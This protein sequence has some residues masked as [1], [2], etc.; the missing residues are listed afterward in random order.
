MS[1][2]ITSEKI[3]QLWKQFWESSPRDHKRAKPDSLIPSQEDKTVLF[4][5]AWMQQFVPYLMGK[6]H[7]LGKRLY[8]IQKCV[9]TWDIDEVGDERHLTFFEMMGNW[10]L[11]DYFKKEAISWSYEFLTDY[12][13]IPSNKIWATI[14]KWEKWIPKD[15]ESQKYWQQVGVPAERIKPLGADDNF[16]GPA[17]EIW[18]CGPSTEIYVDRWPAWGP[19]DR[20]LGT[21]DRYIEVWNDVFMEFYKDKQ[22]NYTPLPQKNVDTWMGLERITMIMQEV[23]TVFETDLFEPIIKVIAKHWMVDYPLEKYFWNADKPEVVSQLSD[24]KELS[25]LSS[26][27][28]GE[29]LKKNIVYLNSLD[30]TRRFRIIADHI[31]SSV[32]LIADGVSPSNEG[33]WY[34]LRR[35]IRRLYYNFLLLDNKVDPKNVTPFVSEV[36]DI[37]AQKYGPWRQNV[38]TSREQVKKVLL[39]EISKFQKTIS[40]GMKLLSKFL[41]SATKR[42][43]GEIVFK[44]YDTYGFPAELTQ[45]IAQSKGIDIDWEGFEAQ[46]QKAK[47][48]S[49]QGT[50]AVFKRWVDWAKYIS[51]LPQTEFVG[52]DRLELDWSS[53]LRDFRVEELWWQRVLVFDKTPFYPEWG[54][55]KGDKGEIIL[56]DWKRLRVVDTQKFAWVI[57]HFV[58]E[59]D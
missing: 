21:N 51:W 15:E 27:E 38:D 17:W 41:S 19:D 47:D 6:P 55:Q 10:S 16:W 9:R 31:R 4:T 14:F 34:V 29:E 39:D 57:L 52:Y 50:S 12:L 40:G 58:K 56:D 23:P 11:W 24:S 54:W 8:N 37:I 32:F 49:R 35:L 13:K 22:G 44:L 26:V 28:A 43:D 36:V 25:T 2:K 45:E 33:R 42:L 59:I 5:T 48:K 30:L 46:M 20:N 7:P 3:R 18:P 53:L 1:E